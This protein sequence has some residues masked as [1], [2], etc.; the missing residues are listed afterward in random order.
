[1]VD[2]HSKWP[3]VIGPM[4][5][6]TAAAITNAMRSIFARY[7]LP[8]QIVSNNGPPFQSAEYQEFLQQSGIQRVLVS[9][10]HPSSNGLAE[11]FVQTSKYALESSASDPSCSLQQRICNFLL[12]Y[13]STPQATT[14]SSPAK[15]FLQKELRTRLSQVRPDLTSHV[16]GQ[17][18]KM[19]MHHDK[20]ARF[21]E[22]AVGDTVLARDH[23]SS[24]KWQ[25]GIVRQHSSPH[26]YQV[27][28]DDGRIWKHHVEDVL[29]NSPSL[30]PVE[31]GTP[32]VD[33]VTSATSAEVVTHSQSAMSASASTPP[34]DELGT[35][36]TPP[37]LRRSLRTSTVIEQC[38]CCQSLHHHH[39]Y[40]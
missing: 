9:T 27:Q 19:K 29:Q 26:S 31:S 15:L 11:R 12:S 36:D 3:E 37:V 23:L 33:A 17:Q 4:K 14:G 1:M 40:Y 39:F 7:G 28:L 21:R 10:Y 38:Y 2:A 13:R 22:M 8:N 24:Q 18:S 32:P 5:T 16:L 20:H 34:Q 35:K 30:K 25:P 6:T